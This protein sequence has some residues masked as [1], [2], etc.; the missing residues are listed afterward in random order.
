[1]VAEVI[2][3]I[4]SRD[5]KITIFLRSCFL[6][7]LILFVIVLISQINNIIFY[8]GIILFILSL[9]PVFYFGKMIA[10][11][12]Y[13]NANT[14]EILPFLWVVFVT[15]VI[16]LLQIIDEYNIYGKI[17]YFISLIILLFL[18]VI[19]FFCAITEKKK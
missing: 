7:G 8:V 9:F 5:D 11:V 6:A 19:I 3:M 1:M 13:K 14:Q 16:S 18:L 4:C 10:E 12:D 15:V 2:I 17:V